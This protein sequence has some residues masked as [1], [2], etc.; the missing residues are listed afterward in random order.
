MSITLKP[1]SS[2][3]KVTLRFDKYVL[4]LESNKL[5]NLFIKGTFETIPFSIA[6][7]LLSL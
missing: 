7:I 2:S 6:S 4:V 5:N 1:K 3:R